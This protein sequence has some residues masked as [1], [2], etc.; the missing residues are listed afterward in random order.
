[1]SGGWTP[2]HDAGPLPHYFEFL[3]T[4]AATR[5]GGAGVALRAQQAIAQ[6]ITIMR[7][8]NGTYYTVGKKQH[9]SHTYATEWPRTPAATP[10]AGSSPW[11][12]GVTY[13]T[14]SSRRPRMRR[15]Q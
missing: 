6:G 5:T 12:R 2:K 9:I 8:S 15:P 3:S 11:R 4:A 7:R 14:E 1:M 13:I 10:E